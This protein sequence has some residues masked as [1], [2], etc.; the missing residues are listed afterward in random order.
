MK[1]MEIQPNLENWTGQNCFWGFIS[2]ILLGWGGKLMTFGGFHPTVAEKKKIWFLWKKLIRD[3]N[4]FFLWL[5]REKVPNREVGD[6]KCYH[7]HDRIKHGMS[8]YNLIF[9]HSLSFF[10]VFFFFSFFMTGSKNFLSI[11]LFP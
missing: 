1:L 2:R 11:F 10:P 9:F 3:Y 4:S 6:Q 5:I 7:C 8:N